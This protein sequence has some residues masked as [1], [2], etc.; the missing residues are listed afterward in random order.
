[1]R[2]IRTDNLYNMGMYETL[3]F[4]MA[5]ERTYIFHIA[6]GIAQV[7]TKANRYSYA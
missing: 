2:K 7:E 1:M 6:E 3:C 4:I 5:N